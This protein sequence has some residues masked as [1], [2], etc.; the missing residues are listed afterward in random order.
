[1]DRIRLLR[2]DEKAFQFLVDHIYGCVHGKREWNTLK[3]TRDARAE[4]S[5]SDEAFA[6]VVLENN[7]NLLTMPGGRKAQPKYTGRNSVDKDDGWSRLGVARFNKLYETVMADREAHPDV[8]ARTKDKLFQNDYKK[9]VSLFH[10]DYTERVVLQGNK[11]R[12]GEE[13]QDEARD[14]V[15]RNEEKTYKTM[16]V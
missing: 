12:R 8:D 15:T 11:R 10:E 1:M 2:A 6:I 16:A 3:Y 14:D 7:W 5:V 9:R 4:L 13:D